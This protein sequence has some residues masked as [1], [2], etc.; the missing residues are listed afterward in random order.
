VE[1]VDHTAVTTT[2]VTIWVKRRNPETPKNATI[3]AMENVVICLSQNNFAYSQSSW[4][5]ITVATEF[6]AQATD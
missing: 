1:T 6:Q 4:S 5:L 3:F 2:A